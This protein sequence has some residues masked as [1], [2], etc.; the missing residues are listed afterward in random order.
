LLAI[1]AVH[2]ALFLGPLLIFTPKLAACR[3]RAMKDYM[4]FAG[5]CV[6]DFDQKWLAGPNPR[7]ALLGTPDL[8]SLADLANSVNIAHSMRPAPISK[9]LVV[10]LLVAALVP[11]L[12][13]LKYPVAE[14]IG[15]IVKRLSGP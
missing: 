11:M 7:E 1:L 3:V 2:A 8:Q 9:R 15:I 14:L 12:P 6:N 4:Q 13:L 10:Q 5:S